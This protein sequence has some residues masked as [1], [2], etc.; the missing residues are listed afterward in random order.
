MLL[1]VQNE[2]NMKE[3]IP[4]TDEH[5]VT[6]PTRGTGTEGLKNAVKDNLPG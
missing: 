2:F 3:K 5:A 4:G 1:Y 6:H